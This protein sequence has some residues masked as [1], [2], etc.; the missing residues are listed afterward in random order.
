MQRSVRKASAAAGSVAAK[1]VTVGSA[2]QNGKEAVSQTGSINE[3]LISHGIRNSCNMIIADKV[4]VMALMHT[5]KA[6]KVGCSFTGADGALG[7][8]ADGRGIVIEDGEGALACINGGELKV[9][10]G[11]VAT[12]VSVGD[13]ARLDGIWEGGTPK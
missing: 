4:T 10:E 7:D 11:G 12:R 13:K 2:V 1:A 5:Q 6:K 3:R 9:A 8:S